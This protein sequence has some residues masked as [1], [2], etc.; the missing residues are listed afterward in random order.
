LAGRAI[1]A[2]QEVALARARGV[3]R[4]VLG[5]IARGQARHFEGLRHRSTATGSDLGSRTCGALH[6]CGRQILHI[7]IARGITFHDAHTEALA[8]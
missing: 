5:G 7:G 1:G 6:R 8:D 4:H 2:Q 3:E